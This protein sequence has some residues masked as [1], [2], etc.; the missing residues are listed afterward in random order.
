MEVE[1]LWQTFPDYC[2]LLEHFGADNL[3]RSQK[4]I[5]WLSDADLVKI[6]KFKKEKIVEEQR[7]ERMLNK[8]NVGSYAYEV[9]KKYERGLRERLA[10]GHII[11]RSV[12]LALTPAIGLMLTTE[13]ALPNYKKLSDYLSN[14]P[15]QQASIPGFISF[16]NAR[17]ELNMKTSLTISYKNIKRR[18]KL[19]ELLIMINGRAW[20]RRDL[21]LWI[22]ISLEYCHGL[23]LTS[24]GC[25]SVQILTVLIEEPGILC[26]V[27]GHDYF[28][29]LPD[30]KLN[31]IEVLNDIDKINSNCNK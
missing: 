25:E 2:I 15:G 6:D 3:R 14:H 16:L 31:N 7:I 26:R 17:Y 29:P 1:Q 24:M 20:A 27:Y 23:K 28:L 18:K 22:F 19:E 13:D 8:L 9:V 11:L 30:H 10:S 5:Q 12:R 21:F 4:V